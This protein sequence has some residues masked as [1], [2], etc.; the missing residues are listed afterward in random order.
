MAIFNSYVT[1]YQRV[2]AVDATKWQEHTLL[3]IQDNLSVN[4]DDFNLLVPT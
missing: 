4:I 1:N 3:Q 2:F